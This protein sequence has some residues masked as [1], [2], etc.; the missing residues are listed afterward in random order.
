VHSSTATVSS[1]VGNML[2]TTKKAP[3]IQR[4][5]NIF[6]SMRKRERIHKSFG[7]QKQKSLEEKE[8]E[9]EDVFDRIRQRIK[10]EQKERAV[11]K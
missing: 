5:D 11:N 8:E 6:R 9:S 3:V 4:S 7:P 1:I 2:I 10:K